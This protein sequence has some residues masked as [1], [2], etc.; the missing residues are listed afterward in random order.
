MRYMNIKKIENYTI[1]KTLII[2]V[3]INYIF[4]SKKNSEIFQEGGRKH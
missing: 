3:H 4:S 1:G 2:I